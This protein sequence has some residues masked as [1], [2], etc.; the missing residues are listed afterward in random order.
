MVDRQDLVKLYGLVV[1][2]YDTHPVAGA[3]LILWGDLQVLFASYEGDKGFC[4]WKHQH[5]WEIRSWRLYTVSSV[6]VLETVSGEVLSMFTDVSYPLSIKIME[7]MLTH[8]LEID[9]DVVGN[10]MTTAKQLIQFI[11]NQ[12]AATQV[13]SV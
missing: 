7:K 11:K 13:S 6:H 1:Q 2:Y 8:K 4:V 10:D 3:G 5:L 12:L 9:T